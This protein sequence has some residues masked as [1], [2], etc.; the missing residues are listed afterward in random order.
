MKVR[1]SIDVENLNE[2]TKF[3]SKL[4]SVDP[5][6]KTENYAEYDLQNPPL[7]FSMQ[8]SLNRSQLSLVNHFGIEVASLQELQQWKE[9]LENLDLKL[10]VE[11]QSE[12]CF[13]RQDKI[14][15]SDPDYNSW[16]IYFV[17]EHLP[18]SEGL[19]PL[20]QSRAGFCRPRAEKNSN[21]R[22]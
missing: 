11:K 22:I 2:S 8:T 20:N 1:V 10:Q 13:A 5:Q 17:Y 12:C 21:S 19:E 18:L 16:E 7:N 9:R 6:K 3:Y 14:W 4:F 15:V